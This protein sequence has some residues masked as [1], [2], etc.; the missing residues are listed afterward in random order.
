ML[1]IQSHRPGQIART[2]GQRV[3]QPGLA[4]PPEHGRNTLQGF[5]RPHQYRMGNIFFVGDDIE[6]MMDALD[7]VYISGAAFPVHHFRPAGPSP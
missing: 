7:Q 2:A 6:K 5:Q 1:D 4:R 3:I